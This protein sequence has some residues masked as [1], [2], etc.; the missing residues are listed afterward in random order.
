MLLR[1]RE[2]CKPEQIVQPALDDRIVRFDLN[3]DRSVERRSVGG[4]KFEPQRFRIEVQSRSRSG[5]VVLLFAELFESVQRDA[6]CFDLALRAGR[7]RV[8][9]RLESNDT[10]DQIARAGAAF[11]PFLEV[12]EEREKDGRSNGREPVRICDRPID[13]HSERSA[14]RFRSSDEYSERLGLSPVRRRPG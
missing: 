1:L 12:G 8:E 14:G 9:H 5:K 3:I 10:A 13:A 6:G 2:R 7:I 4:L 11:E